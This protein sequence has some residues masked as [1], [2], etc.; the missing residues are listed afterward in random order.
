MSTTIPPARADLYRKARRHLS[1]RC[2]VMKALIARV[3]PCTLEPKP[4]DP[5]TLLVG[6]VIAQQISTKAAGSIFA[7]LAGAVGGPP[8]PLERLVALTEAEFRACGVSAP[9]QRTLRAVAGHVAADPGLLP[10][11]TDRDDDTIRTQLTAI[12]GI[13]PWSVDMFLMFGICKP[14]ILPV[15][16]LGLRAGIQDLFGLRKL[17]DADRVTRIAEPWRP[18]RT[19]ATWYVWRSRGFVPQSGQDG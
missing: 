1:R 14:D 13:G 10:G 2:P 3:G 18:Y 16:D 17:P 12:K 6:C 4:D 11:I 7:K 19:I 9:K 15:G 5:F 8:V